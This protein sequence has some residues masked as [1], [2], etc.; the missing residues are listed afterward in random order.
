MAAD[1]AADVAADALEVA[2]TPVFGPPDELFPPE[3]AP[4]PIGVP[5]P[6]LPPQLDKKITALKIIII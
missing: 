2:E 4:P 3:V 1:T 5:P 6:L